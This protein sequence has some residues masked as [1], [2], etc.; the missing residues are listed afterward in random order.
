MFLHTK[1][2]LFGLVILNQANSSVGLGLL[3]CYRMMPHVEDINNAANHLK[4]YYR[5]Q[6]FFVV[7][8]MVIDLKKI[9]KVLS[10]FRLFCV[11]IGLQCVPHESQTFLPAHKQ[12]N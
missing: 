7:H 3:F 11:H 5:L 8:T 2:Q 4:V 9:S 6:T 1:L 10:S 12:T